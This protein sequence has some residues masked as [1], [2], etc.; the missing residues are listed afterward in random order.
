MTEEKTKLRILQRVNIRDGKS[1]WI[2]Q[3]SACGAKIKVNIQS[4]AGVKGKKCGCGIVYHNEDLV[5]Y[6]GQPERTVQTNQG[7]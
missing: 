2:A 5:G 1:Y 7:G 6:R 3:C 4:F